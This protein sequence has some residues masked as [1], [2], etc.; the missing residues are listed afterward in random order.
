M[1]AGTG[2]PVPTCGLAPGAARTGPT[3]PKPTFQRIGRRRL[4][5]AGARANVRSLR[6]LPQGAGPKARKDSSA[7]ATRGRSRTDAN[8]YRPSLSPPPDDRRS[9]PMVRVAALRGSSYRIVE[10]GDP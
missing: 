10:T 5:Q 9:K 8:T 6:R 3:Q 7:Q 2:P 1:D 4:P